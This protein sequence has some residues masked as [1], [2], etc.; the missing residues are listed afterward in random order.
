MAVVAGVA[1]PVPE[2]VIETSK[3]LSVDTSPPSWVNV[4]LTSQL[5]PFEP[6]K[7][8]LELLPLGERVSS[9]RMPLTLSPC[10]APVRAVTEVTGE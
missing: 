8:V 10:I 9:T 3:M 6:V 4:P 7:I 2:K 5:M 1:Q